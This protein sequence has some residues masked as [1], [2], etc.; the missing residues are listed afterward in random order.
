MD[1]LRRFAVSLMLL[2]AFSGGCATIEPP[3]TPAVGPQSSWEEIRATPGLIPRPPA[4]AFGARTVSALNV[5]LS[6][7]TL[8]ATAG[9]GTALEKPAAGI[10]RDYQVGVGV[11]VG[12]GETSH[13]RILFYKPF[14]IPPCN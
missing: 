3:A 11:Q 14:T 8:R 7:D 10:P 5:C 1:L 9:D 13:I 2:A 4:I 12:D 6:G